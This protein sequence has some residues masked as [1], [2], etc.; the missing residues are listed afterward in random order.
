MP[1]SAARDL[2]MAK[3]GTGHGAREWSTATTVAFTRATREPNY[4]YRV[5]YDSR[6]RLIAS[7]VIP[8]PTPTRPGPRPFP[9]SPNG[10]VP[11]PPRGG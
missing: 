7:G 4:V 3:L 10:Y 9:A 2:S 8:R 5:E 6:E 11:D 1:P